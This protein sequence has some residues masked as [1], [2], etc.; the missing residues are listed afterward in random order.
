MLEVRSSVKEPGW[1]SVGDWVSDHIS[2]LGDL[3]LGQDSGSGVEFDSGL[4]A[5]N[6]SESSSNSS[7]LSEGEWSLS[8]TVEIG[9]QDSENELEGAGIFHVE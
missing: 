8:L 6:D 2:D 7:D 5:K 9:V 4:V 3:L 1:D